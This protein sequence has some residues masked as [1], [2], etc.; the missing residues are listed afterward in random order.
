M[1]LGTISTLGSG[2]A[3][4]GSRPKTEG[5]SAISR[6]AREL[7]QS[8]LKIGEIASVIG[9][10]ETAAFTRSFERLAGVTPRGFRSHLDIASASLVRVE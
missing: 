3:E 4:V 7:L 5:S 2:T 9:Y 1:T 8:E 6:A 10:P